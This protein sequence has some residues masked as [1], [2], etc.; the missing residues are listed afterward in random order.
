MV[1]ANALSKAQISSNASD[2]TKTSVVWS[3]G[4]S[5]TGWRLP[6][7]VEW[8]FAARGG[9]TEPLQE[10]QR[11]AMIVDSYASVGSKENGYGTFDQVEN[12]AEWVWG[13]NA[14]APAEAHSTNKM[15]VLLDRREPI[16]MI[17]LGGSARSSSNNIDFNTRRP[18]YWFNVGDGLGVPAGEDS[19]FRDLLVEE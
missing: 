11:G 6:T 13:T 19:A 2:I 16:E 1:F 10:V 12:V 15:T 14:M 4:I 17:F 8:V 18:R 7:E 9:Q 3:M 5:C